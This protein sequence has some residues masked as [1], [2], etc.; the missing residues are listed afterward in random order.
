MKTIENLEAEEWRQVK[1]SLDLYQVSNKGRIKR[2]CETHERLLKTPPTALGYLRFNISINNKSKSKYVHVAVAEAFIPNP[3]KKPTV[4]HK[5]G[6]KTNN[7]VGNLEWATRSENSQHAWD[8]GLFSH[9]K[10]KSS[11]LLRRKKEKSLKENLI[12]QILGV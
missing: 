3:E 9:E 5:D 1:N 4:N 6:D 11:Q 12:T 7:C 8:T 2:I 10:M